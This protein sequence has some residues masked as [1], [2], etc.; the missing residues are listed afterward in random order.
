MRQHGT[1]HT[2]L[3]SLWSLDSHDE[4]V[5]RSALTSRGF[6]AE[7][8]ARD[9]GLSVHDVRASLE[10]LRQHGL[11]NQAA[12]GAYGAVDPRY[13]LRALADDHAARLDRVRGGISAFADVFE[14]ARR[15]AVEEGVT[16]IVRG[17][18]AISDW[19][20]RLNIQATRELLS[21]D[22]P[23]YVLAPTT[24]IEEGSIARGVRWR[25]VYAAA[26]LEVEGGLDRLRA[27]VADGE[28]ARITET[29]PSKLA[30]ADGELGLIGL[31]L[32]ATEPEALV[33]ESP[34]LIRALT[35]L[36]EAEWS[37][38]VPFAATDGATWRSNS[39]ADPQRPPTA[40]ERELLT[41]IAGGVKDDA[42]A[43]QLGMSTRTIRRRIRMLF[44][45]LGATNRFH[46][47]VQAAQR[48]WF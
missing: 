18:A 41:L 2:D 26:S 11:V 31:N 10:A 14:E 30:I 6:S 27:N 15:G 24:A 7:E 33:T 44:S 38:G 39:R 17:A 35:T 1:V 46:A 32:S 34:V 19:Y 8:L 48:G 5:Y 16:R 47:G 28:E 9:I 25:A 29:L 36:F 20:Y 37:R 43:R 45:E 21:F 42:I 12:T 22:L 3:L 23:P 40:A 4:Q 13:A